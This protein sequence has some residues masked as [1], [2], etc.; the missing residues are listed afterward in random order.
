M[1]KTFQFQ[2]VSNQPHQVEAVNAVVDLFAGLPRQATD[3]VMSGEIIGNHIDYNQFEI[4]LK[5]NLIDVQERNKIPIEKAVER[6]FK[7]DGEQMLEWVNDFHECPH[8]TIEMETGSGKTY[9]YI[10]TMYE[11]FTRYG[12]RKFII[13]VPSVAIY[14][15]VKKTFDVTDSH[16]MKDFDGW[17]IDEIAYDGSKPNA[18]RDF[19]I[20]P[21]PMCLIM[22]LDSFNKKSNNIFKVSEKLSD[23]KLPY[24]YIQDTRPIIILDEPQNMGSDK[25]Q[26]AIHTLK[27]LFVLRYSATHKENP[28]LVYR[29]T[30]FEA[31]RQGLVKRIQVAGITQKDNVNDVQIDL[32]EIKPDTLTAIVRTT[33]M[34]GGQSSIRDIELADKTGKNDLYQRTGREEHRGYVVSEINA[35]DGFIAF[36]NGKRF[37]LADDGGVDSTKEAIFRRQIRE[38][39]E[40]HMIRQ[41]E[42][43]EL[44][45]KVLSLFFI[46]R[47]ANYIN[48]GIIRRIFD[49]EFN[50]LKTRFPYYADMEADEVQAA[51][52]AQKQNKET[53]QDEFVDTVEGNDKKDPDKEANKRAFEL[54]MRAKERLLSLEGDAKKVAFIFAHS[55]LK[56]GW[57]NPNVFQICTLN[58]TLS[59]TKKRQEIGRGL[60]LCVNQEG[61]RLFDESVNVLTVIANE[62][63][64]SYVDSLQREY[65]EAGYD[66]TPPAPTQAKKSEAKRNDT[67]FRS[68]EFEGFWQRLIQRTRYRVHIDTDKLIADCIHRLNNATYPDT[69]IVVEKGAFVQVKVTL[70]LLQIRTNDVQIQ[71]D[72]HKTNTD[73]S[74]SAIG[75]KEKEDIGKRTKIEFL[76]GL[77]IASVHPKSRPP[78]VEL[79][80]KINLYLK[81]PYEQTFTESISNTTHVQ[82]AVTERYAVFDLIGRAVKETDLTRPTLN[83]I[84]AGLS[85]K[86]KR[87]VL[88]NPE[89]FANIFIR[90]I[91][92]E[93][94]NHIVA[95]LEFELIGAKSDYDIEE[96]FPPE[97]RHPQRELIEAGANG[98]YDL[99]QKDSDVEENFVRDRLRDNERVLFYFKFPP[100]YKVAMPRIIGNYNPDWGIVY[101]DEHGRMW[102]QLVRETKGTADLEKLRFSN[103]GRKIRLA[104]KHFRAIGIDYRHITDKTDDWYLPDDKA[105]TKLGGVE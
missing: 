76:R 38:T 77:Q 4:P 24:Q 14:E 17:R 35:K 63:Y 20:S 18:L 85:E 34:V 30:P 51:Y 19:A 59:E 86:T 100:K 71:V 8:F 53:K 54:I 52:F 5:R 83:A 65:R 32:R 27:P 55:A 66:E 88:D 62:S 11:L 91:K 81:K 37:Y 41:H 25:S 22:T 87:K 68:P 75:L 13:V 3:E 16:F 29:L 10:R 96:L 99:V 45:V 90:I 97:S 103:E 60:R 21:T 94:A 89:G 98:L 6:H 67:H 84:F 44:G 57:D 47:V 58:Q 56:E 40:A 2:F 33:A 31:F 50:K 104:Q 36:E 73:Y 72:I 70:T 23:G 46:D 61:E 39:I 15:G 49:E 26:R 78:Y 12:F 7:F 82:K 92:D 9:V 28:N 80:N 69:T 105:Q 102:L 48:N 42:L 74:T 95:H 101:Q 79:D 93:L 43:R 1:A 64:A